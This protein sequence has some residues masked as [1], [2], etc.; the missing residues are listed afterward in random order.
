ML[1]ELPN[2]T[3]TPRR[4]TLGKPSRPD[5]RQEASAPNTLNPR[6]ENGHTSYARKREP[7]FAE[8]VEMGEIYIRNPI[9]TEPWH[10]EVGN[11][12][13]R[14]YE[15]AGWSRNIY[16]QDFSMLRVICGSRHPREIFLQDLEERCPVG[17]DS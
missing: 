3:K 13:R 17:C 15:I 1:N 8:G 10:E 11:L 16:M 5:P 12:L 4:T 9:F 14:R 7:R 6:G 2:R